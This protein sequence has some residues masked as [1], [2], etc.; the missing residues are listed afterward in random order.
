VREVQH[1][2]LRKQRPQQQACW[3]FAGLT[4]GVVP[5][6]AVDGQVVGMV[7]WCTTVTVLIKLMTVIMP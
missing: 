3:D 5:Q 2:S 6:L 4:I 1:L 7:V